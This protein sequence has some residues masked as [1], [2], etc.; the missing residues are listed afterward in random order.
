MAAAARWEKCVP[1]GEG[2]VAFVPAHPPDWSISG[3]YER[4]VW[5]GIDYIA[6]VVESPT[7]RPDG[8]ILDRPGYDPGTGLIYEP[9][10]TYPPI[11][12][13]PGQEDA[14][15]AARDLLALVDE[16]PFATPDHA[17]VW[18]AAVLTVLARPAIAG[19]CPLFLFEAPTAGS[20]K[21][22]LAELVGLITTGREAAV[23]ELSDDNEEVRKTI[24]SILL[25]GERLVL[26]DNAGG[27]FGCKALDAAITGT[28]YKG[29]ILGQTKR[30]QEIPVDT[31]WMASGN[32]LQLR[33][34][35][36]RRVVPCRIV[37]LTDHP[38]ERTNFRIP[39]LKEHVRQARP[40]LVVA[41]LTIL[42]AHV[43]AGRPVAE[44]SAFGSFE[45]WSDVVRQAVFWSTGH[46]PHAARSV[47]PAESRGN[48]ALVAVLEAW[49][50][51]PG[52]RT[53]ND[54]VTARRALELA[55]Q[56]GGLHEALLEWGK[57]GQLPDTQALG[58]RLRAARDKVA[59]AWILRSLPDRKG[60][61]KWW[62]EPVGAGQR[63]AGAGDAGDCRASFHS[64]RARGRRWTRG[65]ISPA[66]PGIPG[67]CRRGTTNRSRRRQPLCRSGVGRRIR[68]RGG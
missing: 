15:R 21:T 27:S 36:P 13:L 20:G 57:E 10:A 28:T 6:G 24:T 39:N 55:G 34:D 46:D 32:N 7:L 56:V 23:S 26:F 63:G 67:T 1:R 2:K 51:L 4:G 18:L 49:S 11:P 22:L 66:M 9:A 45:A 42:K 62:V 54:G 53:A 8:T 60:L 65:R 35:M 17:A 58:Y 12:E 33:G 61:G 5:P 68:D 48:P 16:F 59:G 52:G 14:R 50:R 3:V 47:I 38:E 29:R 40:E 64:S 43:L 30:T 37:P 44:L 41:A 31:V 25:E 19:P